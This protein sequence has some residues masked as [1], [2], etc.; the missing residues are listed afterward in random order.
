MDKY[1]KYIT[2]TNRIHINLR[3]VSICIFSSSTSYIDVIFIKYRKYIKTTSWIYRMSPSLLKYNLLGN[4][5]ISYLFK[6]IALCILGKS[7]L[8]L[9]QM[10]AENM[11]K[12]FEN[13]PNA[14]PKSSFNDDL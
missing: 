3:L 6:A 2:K 13:S 7:D 11:N 9:S 10:E 4:C 12:T 1:I 5:T 14:E 8:L